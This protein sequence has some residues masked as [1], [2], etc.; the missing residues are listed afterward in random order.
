MIGIAFKV[1]V[2]IVYLFFGL[3]QQFERHILQ[4]LLDAFLCLDSVPLEVDFA[5]GVS[6]GMQPKPLLL[7]FL[8]LPFFLLELILLHAPLLHAL[9]A[10]LH[11]FHGVWEFYEAG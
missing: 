6:A 9:K 5:D 1:L 7:Q 4:F 11:Y 3:L 2:T 8:I 10:L